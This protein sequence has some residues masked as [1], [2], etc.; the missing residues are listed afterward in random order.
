M[1]AGR[2]E[3]RVD[4]AG[5]LHV[6]VG[7]DSFGKEKLMENIY[8]LLDAVVRLKPPASKGTYIKGVAI[9]KTMSP[10]VKLDPDLCEEPEQIGKESETAG[11]ALWRDLN[12]YGLPRLSCSFFRLSDFP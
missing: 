9:S 12:E 5:N 8:S 4:K 3:F 10:G 1:K 7:K 11:V 6:P 2:V